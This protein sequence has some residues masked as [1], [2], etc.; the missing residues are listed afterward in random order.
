V[1]GV[2]GGGLG[3]VPDGMARVVRECGDMGNREGHEVSN[4]CVLFSFSFSS[5]DCGPNYFSRLAS[6]I[7]TSIHHKITSKVCPNI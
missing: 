4:A 2:D 6:F 3:T 1:A 7:T 5:F